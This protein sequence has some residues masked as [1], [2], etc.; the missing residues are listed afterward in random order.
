MKKTDTTSRLFTEVGLILKTRLQKAIPMPFSQYQTL[1]FV[2][3]RTRVNM[4]EVA[5]HFKI[6]AP[7][8]TFLVEELVRSGLVARHANTKD[9]RKVE[10]E[11]TAK[12]KRT[13]KVI[14]EKRDTILAK[15]FGSLEE[16]DRQ[17]LNRILESIINNA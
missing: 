14:H 12:G 4:Q 16:K 6:R 9:R 3:E 1:Q 13:F 5:Q 11:L 15:L 8:A 7:S 17:E 10:I 2:A